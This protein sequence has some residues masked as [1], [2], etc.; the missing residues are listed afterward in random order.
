MQSGSQWIAA[1]LVCVL[2]SGCEEGSRGT[3]VS[4]VDSGGIEIVTNPRSFPEVPL[5]IISD[6]FLSEI[7][8]EAL[9]QI[10]GIQPLPDGELAV[11]VNGE[12]SVLLFN[13][14]GDRLATLGRKGDGPGEFR[15]VGSPV[16]L[17]GDSLGVYDAQARRLTIFPPD[18]GV[19]RVVSLSEIAPG[20]GWARVLPLSAGLAFVGE[21]GLG[22]GSDQGVYR[23]Q[24][25]SY[26]INAD[27]QV[28]S[29]YGRFPGLQ[30]FTGNMMMGRAPFGA[31][32]ATA[33]WEDQFIVGTGEIPGL[34]FFG[35]DGNLTR[36][37][38][39]ADTDRAVTQERMN[40]HIE[41]LLGQVPPEQEGAMRDRLEGMPYASQM[42][43]HSEVLI[44]PEGVIWVGEY[45]GPE[46]EFP[47]TLGSVS[48]RWVV[49]GPDGV[50]RDRIQTPT[51][52][53]PMSLGEDIVWGVYRNDLDVESVRAYEVGF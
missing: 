41:F 39:W 46:A 48:R 13:S 24:E 53:I 42:P 28:L 45:A 38:R 9:Y 30:A 23:N 47:T 15:S 25:E 43:T 8:D 7:T 31:M 3:L 33:T 51:G 4:V 5:R 12:G 32:L 34:R 29:T 49:F 10:S 17:P 40:Q 18:S 16:P 52:F 19:P 21:A 1:G 37:I 2:S 11:G 14:A 6:D 27:G 22:G 26:R 20:R 35:P 44:S 50:I 36:I